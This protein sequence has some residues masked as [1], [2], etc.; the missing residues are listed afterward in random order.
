MGLMYDNLLLTLMSGTNA[1]VDYS[2]P[3][4]YRSPG[5][6]DWISIEKSTSSAPDLTIEVSLDKINWTTIG[7][8]AVP[9]GQPNRNNSTIYIMNGGGRIECY[10]MGTMVFSSYYVSDGQKLYI[11]G[12][13]S[14][15]Y[16][17]AVNDIDYNYINFGAINGSGLTE[18]GG[19]I[20]SL[21]YG[22]NFN[23]QD[24]MPLGTRLSCL[25]RQTI[26]NTFFN[27]CG[28]NYSNRLVFPKNTQPCCYSHLFDDCKGLKFPEFLPATTLY[29]SCYHSM[30]ESSDIK[31][32]PILP[33]TTLAE[34]C[35][36]N[37]FYQ[38]SLLTIPPELPAT[39][40]A[41]RCYNTMFADCTSLTT[42]PELPATTLVKRCYAGMFENCSNLEYIKC[43]ATDIS[44]NDCTALWVQ[45][46][47]ST[48]T[49][50]KDANMSSWTSGNNGI[51]TGWTVQNA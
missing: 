1:P 21:V 17:T 30:F 34:S 11:R 25:F 29:L 13:S 35:Y 9:S 23:G 51:P 31:Q 37:M 36:E 43:L 44:A 5:L 49:F 38:C 27:H 45:N 10:N 28:I 42:A 32:A 15:S 48:G 18:I 39:T 12:T 26:S 40:L 2:E 4:Y 47:S 14:N 46:I 50:V 20:L 33:S 8:T 19:N 22:S 16:K 41:E 24:T 7:T 6:V 3:F